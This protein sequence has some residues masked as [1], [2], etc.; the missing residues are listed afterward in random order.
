MVPPTLLAHPC[1]M[2]P[3]VDLPALL[4]R[5]AHGDRSAFRA[6]YDATQS[7]LFPVARRIT[8]SDSTAADVL[9]ESYMAMWH[10]ADSYDPSRAAVMTWMTTIV[11]NRC[12][13]RLGSASYRH[14]TALPEEDLDG[15]WQVHE[16]ERDGSAWVGESLQRERL[17]RCLG[18]LDG[19][20]RQTVALAFLRGLSHAEVA[21]H[22]G[23]PLGSVKG[24]IRRALSHLKDCL[25]AAV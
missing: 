12:F 6:L 1:A 3:D 16:H 10:R 2:L 25:G 22:L 24:W 18:R 15:L 19:R 20:Q 5:V 17:Q 21:Q 14:E 23:E 4:A 9:Q 11:R 8:G 13:D 7:H